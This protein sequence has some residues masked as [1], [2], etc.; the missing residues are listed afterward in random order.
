MTRSNSI[1]KLVSI[2]AA[3]LLAVGGSL[4]SAQPAQALPV[5]DNTVIPQFFG[6][7]SIAGEAQEFQSGLWS[8]NP[9]SYVFD[10][11]KCAAN[12]TAIS[13]CTFLS[14]RSRTSQGSVFFTPTA[15]VA[16]F[17][18][19]VMMTVTSSS[20]TTV[21]PAYR[22]NNVIIVPKVVTFNAN[23]GTL[24]SV[25]SLSGLSVALPTLGMSQQS[26]LPTRSG[27]F[28]SGWSSTTSAANMIQQANYTPMT[29][30][31][32]YAIWAGA[33][34]ASV[35][36][37]PSTPTTSTTTA[38]IPESAK[39]LPTW[40]APILK[41]VPDLSKTLTTEG[42]KVGLSDGDYS[43]LKSVTIGGK[44]VAFSIDAKGDVSIPVPAGKGGTSADL[45][46]TFAGG[47]M[48]IQD[49]IKYVTPTDLATVPESGLAGFAKKS[50][51]LGSALTAAILYAAQVDHKANAI[52]CSG[53]ASSK[54][55]I[56]LATARA[57]AACAV[58][59]GA[60]ETLTKS[61]VVVVVNKAKAK[62]SPV[63]IK[64]YH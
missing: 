31:T 15:S 11:Y 7:S 5:V 19:A 60:Y 26:T 44:A 22:N 24:G 61:N 52:Q 38:V 13:S 42:G 36:L 35:S 3:L 6:A 34:C 40:A 8:E 39:P 1:K 63:G 49:G 28:F 54:A 4:V 14:T 21:S 43:S 51:K 64:V 23:G 17:Y 53:Y 59:T 12:N 32:L 37:T 62:T 29:D 33:N 56:A 47:S 45:V 9:T 10:L 16:G 46:V 27:C 41:Q 57:T 20:G 50:A 58:A 48:V 30:V 25:A 18:L 55:D 2:G